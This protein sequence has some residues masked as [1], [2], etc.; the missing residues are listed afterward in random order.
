MIGFIDVDTIPLPPGVSRSS[1]RANVELQ[2]LTRELSWG[3]PASYR[4]RTE[5][6]DSRAVRDAV[7]RHLDPARAT[8]VHLGPAR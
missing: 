7:A 8:I 1:A 5:A 3:D 4:K 2:R 6:V